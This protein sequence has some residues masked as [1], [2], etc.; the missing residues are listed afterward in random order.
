M[1]TKEDKRP[2]P[3]PRVAT[4]LLNRLTP[5]H[6]RE[7]L[8]GDF[9]EGYREMVAFAGEAGARR[10]YRGQA[11]R[12]IPAFLYQ[13][14]YWSLLIALYVQD[15]LSYDT[16]FSKADRLYRLTTELGGSDVP[17]LLASSPAPAFQPLL[18]DFPEIVQATRPP[19]SATLS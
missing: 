16:H 15:E 5:S 3:L 17:A 19:R 6:W 12:S 1:G 4:W 11:L 8:L 10:W 9:E 14:S 18:N 2:P 13:S 7:V